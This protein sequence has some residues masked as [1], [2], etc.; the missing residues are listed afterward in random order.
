M[1]D[2]SEAITFKLEGQR[3]A[4]VTVQVDTVKFPAITIDDISKVI[5][6]AVHAQI[7]EIYAVKYL[8]ENDKLN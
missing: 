1:A 7:H 5:I 8:K 2:E 4:V 3:L 6:D